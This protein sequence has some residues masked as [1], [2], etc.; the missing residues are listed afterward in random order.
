MHGRAELEFVRADGADRL[1]HLY[2]QAPLRVLF[3]DPSAGEPPQAALVTTSGGL[4][5]G[6]R[7][8][9]DVLAG[10]GAGALILASAAEKVYRS[11]DADTRV[12]VH[13][14][15]EAG[16]ALEYLP[17]ETI[18]FEG[19]RL[20]R[21]TRI[22][23]A[24]DAKVMAGEILVFGRLARGERL[25]RGLVRES[26]EIRRAGRLVW[27]DA[28]HLEQDLAAVLAAPAG[29]DGAAAAACLVA[30]ADDPAALCTLARAANEGYQ[31]RMGASV[32][33]PVL[34]ARWLDRDP[35]RLRDAYGR[36]WAALRREALGRAEALPRL[37]NV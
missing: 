7:L 20:R 19:A 28:L 31:G 27:A 21:A 16:A 22:D 10:P 15:A 18:L 34:V 13:L 32:V 37:W 29:F 9:L 26:W 14:R 11:Q 2:Q 6:D 1:A 23:A 3:P 17:Q 25:S 8:E 5:G 35:R 33:G 30:L 12:A 24:A 4:A 36:T